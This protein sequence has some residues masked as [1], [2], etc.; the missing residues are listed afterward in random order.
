MITQFVYRYKALQAGIHVAV[1][2]IIVKAYNT[3]F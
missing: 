1:V 2:C 3:I